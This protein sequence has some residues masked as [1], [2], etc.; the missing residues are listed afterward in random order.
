[1]IVPLI[2]AVLLVVPGVQHV[3]IDVGSAPSSPSVHLEAKRY[4]PGSIKKQHG[5]SR[6]ATTA[7][8][9]SPCQ[10]SGFM[11]NCRIPKQAVPAGA[12][13][14]PALAEQAVREIPM[15]QL[16]LRV[17]PAGETLV[18]ADT[19]LF[20]EPQTLHTSIDLLGHTITVEAEPIRYIWI[21]GDGTTRTTRTPGAPYPHQDVTH[22]YMRPAAALSARVDTVYAVRYSV[23]GG[24]WSDLGDNL[25]AAGLGT[26]VEVREA[27][28]VLVH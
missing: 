22:R 16:H 23:D 21:H 20:T 2:A 14:T 10:Y 1:M 17:Q 12:V 15:P 25:V 24:G 13:F 28:P 3:G 26:P 8:P 18:N 7:K 9:A 11:L 4:T 27:L 19:I 6:G 5:A